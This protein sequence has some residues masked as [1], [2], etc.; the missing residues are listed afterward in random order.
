M[1]NVNQKHVKETYLYVQAHYLHAMMKMNIIV[2]R[3][4]FQTRATDF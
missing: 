2:V 1:K 3:S 4:L